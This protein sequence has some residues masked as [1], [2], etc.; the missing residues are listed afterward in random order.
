MTEKQQILSL[1][2]CGDE[3]AFQELY[4]QWSS[5]LYG[6]VMK[7]SNG[8]KYLAEEIV[9]DVFITIWEKRET[10]DES[11]SFGNYLCTIAKSRLLNIYK[12]RLVET[13][14]AQVI[15]TTKD[16]KT[17][18]TSENVDITFLNDFLSIIVEEMPDKRR[19]VF[20]LSRIDGLS[21]KEIAEKLDISENT[22]EQHIRKALKHIRTR[23]DKYYIILVISFFS[24]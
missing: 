5:K 21:N 18:Y 8:E 16:I 12:H 10:L 3:A 6:F 14:Y 11:K 19:E 1:K 13:M 2:T 4:H 20:K 24:I 7:V 15:A 22:V 9:Q 23:I 17:D